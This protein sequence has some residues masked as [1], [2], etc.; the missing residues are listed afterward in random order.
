MMT[1][2]S[3]SRFIPDIY[4]SAS[5]VFD[6]NTDPSGNADSQSILTSGFLPGLPA[7]AVPVYRDGILPAAVPAM[8]PSAQ[9]KRQ[10][11]IKEEIADING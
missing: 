4:I 6:V 8:H 9:P 3:Y 5:G 2:S 11:R 7:T 10:F 1:S